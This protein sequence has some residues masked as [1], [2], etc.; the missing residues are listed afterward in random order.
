M[1]RPSAPPVSRYFSTG[2]ALAEYAPFAGI[3]SKFQT[4]V[5]L[6]RHCPVDMRR[7]PLR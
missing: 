3:A 6:G 7:V 2:T 5:A 4:F 1:S